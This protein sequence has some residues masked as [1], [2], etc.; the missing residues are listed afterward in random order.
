VTSSRLEETIYREV[1]K[2]ILEVLK[3]K[4]LQDQKREALDASAILIASNF[5]LYNAQRFKRIA[6]SI[7]KSLRNAKCDIS[8]ELFH[9]EFVGQNDAASY[10]RRSPFPTLQIVICSTTV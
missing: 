4:K 5:S 1:W 8:M 10:F 2:T 6:V 3:V 7:N 9:P